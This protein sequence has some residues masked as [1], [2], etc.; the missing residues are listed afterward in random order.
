MKRVDRRWALL[1]PILA[2]VSLTETAASAAETLVRKVADT[3]DVSAWPN[4]E[5]NSA[6]GGSRVVPQSATGAPAGKCLE[7]D[8]RFSGKGFEWFGVM[9]AQPLVMTSSS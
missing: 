6:E 8:V 4:G 3:M 7:I 5:W 9:P 2:G 1:L